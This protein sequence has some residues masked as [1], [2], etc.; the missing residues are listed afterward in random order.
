VS[1]WVGLLSAVISIVLSIVAILFARDV[2]HRSIE[3][4]DQTIRSLESIRATVQRLSDDTGG[5]IKGAWERMLGTMGPQTPPPDGDIQRLL[6]GLLSEFRQ[7]VDDLAPG[8]G[9]EK[10]ARDMS[11]RVRR[12][13]TG[14]R[15]TTENPL[16]RVGPLTLSRSPLSLF[17]R[18]PS[19]CYERC[20]EATIS[21]DPN[22]RCCGET[23]TWL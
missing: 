10:L 11:D 2:D 17:P 16:P 9:V 12:P 14:S 5:L 18:S 13:P 4:S 19:S 7:D 1:L 20:V 23:R 3:I 21:P 8:S 22:I 6:A 15:A